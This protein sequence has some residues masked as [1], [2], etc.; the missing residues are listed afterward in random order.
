MKKTSLKYRVRAIENIEQLYRYAPWETGRVGVYF[1]R[2]T[3]M[4]HSN[5]NRAPAMTL[6]TC[7]AFFRSGGIIVI[8][9]MKM[10]IVGF[11]SLTV[12]TR[13]EGIIGITEQAI[14]DLSH[15]EIGLRQKIM[16]IV[17]KT[18]REKKL[19]QLYLL[20]KDGMLHCPTP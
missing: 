10:V 16:A 1:D 2:L 20:S 18:V 4:L 7:E 8:A 19:R 3:R 15:R 11:A 6:G 17:I 12:A 5:D 13:P 9:T 14:I